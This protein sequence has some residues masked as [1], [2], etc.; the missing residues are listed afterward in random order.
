M[1]NKKNIKKNN[2][3][4]KEIYKDK[5]PQQ[6]IQMDSE[7]FYDYYWKELLKLEDRFLPEFEGDCDLSPAF[8]EEGNYR[9]ERDPFYKYYAKQ[10][11]LR[12]KAKKGSSKMKYHKKKEMEK[13][14]RKGETFEEY[15]ERRIMEPRD[16]YRELGEFYEKPEGSTE[17]STKEIAER[18][19]SME[20]IDALFI[21]L[22]YIDEDVTPEILY[23]ILY[24]KEFFEELVDE[25]TQI[26]EEE[27]RIFD[28]EYEEMYDKHVRKLFR[29]KDLAWFQR[30]NV[31][32][33]WLE[34]QSPVFAFFK[35]RILRLYF[36]YRKNRPVFLFIFLLHIL[37]F[38]FMSFL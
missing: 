28:L 30:L 22:G 10:Y 6:K 36:N 19:V 21:E 18:G 9:L 2:K 33:M 11:V 4:N 35:K 12:Q 38:F 37:W 29:F 13:A 31:Y 7:E 14:I 32:S 3:E 8:D 24:E 5:Q 25:I 27:D 26:H 23:I 15:I 1:V 16:P 20:E 17:L 34:R